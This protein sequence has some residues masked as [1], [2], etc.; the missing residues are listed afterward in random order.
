MEITSYEKEVI[1][2]ICQ[3]EIHRSSL[4]SALNHPKWV[5]RTFRGGRYYLEINHK[6]LPIDR[7]FCCSLD[8]R[9]RYKDIDVQFIVQ[10]EKNTIWMECFSFE[11]NIPRQIIYGPVEVILNP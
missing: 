7:Q 11:S 5:N 10:I 2:S 8:V 9:G 1:L 4:V 3:K 6:E